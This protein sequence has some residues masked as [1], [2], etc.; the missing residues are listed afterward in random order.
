MSFRAT[1][2]ASALAIL[3]ACGEGGED[4]PGER[5]TYDLSGFTAVEAAAG[6]SVMISQGD[7]AVSA[8]ST[9]GDLSDLTLEVEDGTLK[10]HPDTTIRIGRGP[11]YMVEVTAPDYTGLTAVAGASM[12]GTGLQ[13][14]AVSITGAAGSEMEL[15]GTCTN[16][17]AEAAAGTTL[18]LSGLLCETADLTAAAGARIKAHA[19]QSVSATAAAGATINVSGSP[20]QVEK[21]EALGSSVSVE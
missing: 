5:R 8:T 9:N 1:S 15:T 14:N 18:K 19:T 21:E 12:T 6:V 4:K 13:L 7:F 11:S 2:L 3:A 20:P 16:L 17:E 10:A